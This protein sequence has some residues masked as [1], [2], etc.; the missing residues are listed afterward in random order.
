[1][2]RML[3]LLALPLLLNYCKTQQPLPPEDLSSLEPRLSYRKG[4]CMGTCPVSTITIF[5]N[6]M[7]Q[8]EG[9]RFASKT[10]TFYRYLSQAEWKKLKSRWKNINW[11]SLPDRYPSDVADFPTLTLTYY[12][13]EDS[14]KIMGQEGFPDAL[15]QL[16]QILDEVEKAGRWEGGEMR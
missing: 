5:D 7:V 9:L 15:R 3:L 2:L 4:P 13:G 10:G 8:F 1:M 14:K 6:R 12:E 16:M 11:E